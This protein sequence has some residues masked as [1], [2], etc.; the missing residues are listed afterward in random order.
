MFPGQAGSCVP[1]FYTMPFSV[2][3]V[4]GCHYASRNDK[5]YWLSTM[6]KAPNRPFDGSIIRNH[7]S[8]CVVCEAPA[9]A[10]ALHDPNSKRPPECPENWTSIWQGYSFLMV[11]A[12][13]TRPSQNL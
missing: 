3:G 8:R 10:V 2:C 6:E 9:S 12:R 7:I 11:R 1:M 4:S 13:T 5:T